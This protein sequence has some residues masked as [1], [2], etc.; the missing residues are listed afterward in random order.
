MLELL[1][2]PIPGK[3]QMCPGHSVVRRPTSGPSKH[4]TGLTP[5][6]RRGSQAGQDGERSG[7]PAVMLGIAY[8]LHPLVLHPLSASY[9]PHPL[10]AWTP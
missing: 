5:Q 6:S 10:Q 9:A 1:P 3:T 2:D 4:P 7:E 8:H